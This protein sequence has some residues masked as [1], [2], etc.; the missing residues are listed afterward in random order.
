MPSMGSIT[1]RYITYIFIV[2]IF[3]SPAKPDITFSNTI[4]QFYGFLYHAY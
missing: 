4:L 3:V 1:Y 2:C